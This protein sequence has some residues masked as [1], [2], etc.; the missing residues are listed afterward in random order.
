MNEEEVGTMQTTREVSVV[1][2]PPM[3][4]LEPIHTKGLQRVFGLLRLAMGWTFLWAFID[5]LFGLGFSTGRNV[6]T[7]A[8]VFGGPDAWING[9]SPTAGVLGF[10]LKGPFKGF[11]E[12]ITGFTMTAAGPQAAGWVDWVYM[13]SMLAIG[14]ALILGIGVRLAAV[15]GII[16]MGI[17]YTATA[18]WPEHNPFLDDHVVEAIVL[19]ALFLANAGRYYGLGKVWQN[20]AWVKDRTSLY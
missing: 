11:Y 12:S 1:E 6:E 9:G 13:L 10:A 16:W 7:G 5:K 8:I 20:L 19:A 2:M 18:I 14:L 15:G 3:E 17:F 4:R